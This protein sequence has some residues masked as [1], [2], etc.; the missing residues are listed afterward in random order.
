VSRKRKSKRTRES[1]LARSKAPIAQPSTASTEPPL[2]VFVSSVI[3]GMEKERQVVDQAVQSIP[4]TRPWRFEATPASTEGVVESYL[5]KV[6]ECDIFILLIGDVDSVAVRREYET[7]LDANKPVLAFI[8]DVERTLELDEFVH[9]I[10]TK[11]AVYSGLDDLHLSVRAA[12]VDE[13]VRRYRSAIRQADTE[14]LV[15]FLAPPARPISDIL[16]YVI[17]GLGDE[18]SWA[19]SLWGAVLKVFGGVPSCAELC[20]TDLPFEDLYFDD[21]NE[22]N[23]VFTSLN[24]AVMRAGRMSGDRQTA[25]EQAWKDEIA[26][27]A[28]HFVVR[29]LSSRA[30]PPA[31]TALGLEYI[32]LGV[33][34][35]YSSL[36]RLLR[37]REVVEGPTSKKRDAQEF[38]FKDATVIQQMGTVFQRAQRDSR[39]DPE[40][41]LRLLIEGAMR[42][43][44]S[45]LQACDD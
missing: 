45:T 15:E 34:H 30:E 29:H 32:I 39:G 42:V 4:L 44:I 28:S 16:E 36:I 14:T 2:L 43:R 26:S 31:S 3:C 20:E 5:S 22:M 17:F 21:F 9:S 23:E 33:H 38:V 10:H 6:R 12:V 7:A 40:E 27:R 13:V 41:W 25:F 1:R 37:T 24:R 35:D 11:Y 18:P 8:R 19:V